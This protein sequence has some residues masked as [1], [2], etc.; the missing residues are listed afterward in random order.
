MSLKTLKNASKKSI[1]HYYNGAQKHEAFVGFKNACSRA[2]TYVILAS[3]NY[4]HFYA[5]YCLWRHFLWRPRMR[6]CIYKVQKTCINSTWIAWLIHGF[7]PVKTWL[8]IACGTAFYAIIVVYRFYCMALFHSQT[9]RHMINVY[10]HSRYIYQASIQCS[11]MI[12]QPAKCHLNGVSLAGRSWPIYSGIWIIYPLINTNKTS[13][14]PL[15]KLS[16]SAHGLYG[17]YTIYKLTQI[18]L[19][20]F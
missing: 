5:R 13:G 9:R 11:A 6:T 19:T 2:K 1:L 12:G 14:P 10:S 16:R 15:T 7:L 20:S 8:L 17:L 4:V 3:L 18:S